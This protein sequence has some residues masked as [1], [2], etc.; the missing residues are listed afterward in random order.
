MAQIDLN[1]YL[2]SIAHLTFTTHQAKEPWPVLFLS[3][4]MV[5][6]EG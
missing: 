4:T 3:N 6:P 5:L 1:Y 2:P